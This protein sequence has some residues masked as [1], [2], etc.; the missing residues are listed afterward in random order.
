M[1]TVVYSDDLGARLEMAV[2]CS[3]SSSVRF[4]QLEL[5]RLQEEPVEGFRVRLVDDSNLFVWEVAIFGPPDTL[6][7]GGYFKVLSCSDAFHIYSFFSNWIL[8]ASFAVVLVFILCAV[9]VLRSQ[10]KAV[11]SL[12]YGPVL[13]SIRLAAS[14]KVSPTHRPCHRP[15]GSVRRSV[16]A[17]VGG[18]VESKCKLQG[19]LAVGGT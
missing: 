13:N 16:K 11:C 17:T 6:Y 4:L 19:W 3:S 14:L 9:I 15:T 10:D 12:H 2:P 5:K 8:K 18:S 7:E 1:C